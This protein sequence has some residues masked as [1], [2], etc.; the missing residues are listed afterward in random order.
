M[1]ANT[2][3]LIRKGYISGIGSGVTWGLDA[4]LLGIVMTMSPFVENP[5]LLVGGALAVGT[6]ALAALALNTCFFAIHELLYEF[7]YD[8]MLV[9]FYFSS[10]ILGWNLFLSWIPKSGDTGDHFTSLSKIIKRVLVPIYLFLLLK[11]CLLSLCPF[12]LLQLSS[13]LYVL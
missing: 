6:A 11:V 13:F 10:V 5:I 3:Y 9:I 4:V 2:K 7:S 1:K 8:W 12:L